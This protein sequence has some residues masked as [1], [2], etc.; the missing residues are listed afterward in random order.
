MNLPLLSRQ[1]ARF[2]GAGA[3]FGGGHLTNLPFASLHGAATAVTG[4][5][6]REAA[7]YIATTSLRIIDPSPTEISSVPSI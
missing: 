1:G 5:A 3:A 2:A 6:N 7:A 4:T